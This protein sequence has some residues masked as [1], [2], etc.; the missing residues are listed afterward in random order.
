MQ[1]ILQKPFLT[2]TDIMRV[3]DCSASKASRIKRQISEALKKQGKI[4]MT[5][6][7]PTKCFLDFMC[8]CA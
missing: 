2:N 6:D 3:L 7:I 8:Y 1:A 4:L 5:N